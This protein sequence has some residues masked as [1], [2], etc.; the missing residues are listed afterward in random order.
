MTG[1]TRPISTKTRPMI[2]AAAVAATSLLSVTAWSTSAFAQ[3]APATQPADAAA[4]EEDGV[5][6]RVRP[7]RGERWRGRMRDSADRPGRE[8][9]EGR[10]PP[11]MPTDK[12]W[13][14]TVN[15]LAA[16]S[17]QRLTMYRGFVERV[18]ASGPPA[19]G[20]NAPFRDRVTDRLQARIFGRVQELK[21]LAEVDP[22]L[23]AFKLHQFE[24]EDVIIGSIQQ[25][26]HA[27]RNGDAEG[28]QA[29]EAEAN[30]RI[31]SYIASQLDERQ[32]RI[33]RLQE[34][35]AR[36]QAKLAED[37]ENAG[38][39]VERIRRRFERSV[40]GG[41]GPRGGPRDGPRDGPRG[42]AGDRPRDA[43]KPAGDEADE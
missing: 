41:R 14:E 34:E 35:L 7:R 8:G 39:Y 30:K 1:F 5:E 16:Y 17:P 23:H 43:D 19:G 21:R 20:E 4:S 13:A 10:E 33:D 12:E 18:K 36:E 3:D 25:A 11:P 27:R 42:G 32:Q 28:E 2:L 24:L 31:E 38:E 22:E 40:P 9:R 26:R 15:F 6:D 37:R 29:A